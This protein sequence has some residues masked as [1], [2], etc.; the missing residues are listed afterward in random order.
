MNK[1]LPLLLA[2]FLI[3]LFGLQAQ[4][5][6]TDFLY[7]DGDKPSNPSNYV[8]LN[9]LILF[10][11]T[12]GGEGREL[13]VSDGNGNATHLLKDIFPGRSS[14]IRTSFRES[15]VILGGEL[16]FLAHDGE[17]GNQIW[18]TKGTEQTTR[19][20]TNL[21]GL[22][23]SALTLVGNQIFFLVK[24]GDMLQVWKS[25]G[26][27]QGTV[28]VK[29]GLPAWSQASFEG[30][31]NGLFFF[32]FVSKGA[33][34]DPKLW[35]SDGS[36]SGTFPV[37]R[38]MDGNGAGRGYT[39][40]FTQYIEF[41]DELYLVVRSHTLFSYPTSVGII[42][43]DG[44]VANT[45]PVKAVHDGS[46]RLV[47]YADVIEVNS[48]L[49]FSFF[50][51]DYNRL[52]IWE[53][54]GT[55]AGTKKVYDEYGSKF[56]T[57]SNLNT[58]GKDLIFVGKNGRD[59]TTLL[60]LNLESYAVKEIKELATGLVKSSF[61][62]E[63]AVYQISKLSDNRYLLLEPTMNSTGGW[64]TDLTTANTTHVGHLKGV[65]EV[66]THNGTVYFSGST[67]QQSR[68][69]WKSDFTLTVSGKENMVPR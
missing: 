20:V 12:T 58:D 66:V 53:S 62:R 17:N 16:F 45:V 10:E 32:T 68:E 9:D 2:A 33:S 3:P 28:L 63:E 46:T 18:S 5:Q 30:T 19:R 7:N 22:N 21:S 4:T 69:L 38:E 39:S 50:E 26:T 43:T 51:A 65:R 31:A 59:N 11:A 24:Q 34:V 35:R 23:A 47:D 67:P 8:R 49:Y 13:W 56:Y 54:D 41:N 64:V 57:T 1:L 40:D 52:F 15:H 44:S 42:K 61:F 6:L 25:D 29:D 14:G 36:A 37:T 60:K 48:K 27:A 55:S